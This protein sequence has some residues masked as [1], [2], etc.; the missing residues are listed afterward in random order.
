MRI[1]LAS[2]F[3]LG[4]MCGWIGL[5]TGAAV[6]Q[7][8]VP[9]IERPAD[10]EPV[11]P[12]AVGEELFRAGKFEEARTELRRC[13]DAGGESVDTLLPLTVMAVQTGRR[14]EAI[15]YS[16]RAVTMAPEDAE[17][18]YWHGRALMVAGR[19]EEARLEWEAGMRVSTEHKGILE[20]LAKLAMADGETA[21][22]YNIL[23]QL[24][25]SG[26]DDAWVHSLLADIAASKGLWKQ[27]LIHMDDVAVRETPDLEFLLLASEVSLMAENPESALNYGRSAVR[28]A[29]GP[30]SYAGL[31]EVF[32]AREEV[33]SALVYLRRAVELDPGASRARFNLA[34]ALEV[35]GQVEEAGSHFQAFLAA[36]PNDPVGQFNYGIHLQKLG[37]LEEALSHISR[38][39]DLEPGMLSARVVRVQM[40]EILGRYDEAL[41]D[42]AFLSESDPDNRS[43]LSDWERNIRLKR[44]GSA[45]S[46]AEGQVHLQHLVMSDA[47]AAELVASELEAG[48][49]F[50][51]LV[52]RFSVGP[53]SA[54]GGDIGWINPQDM[55]EPLRAAIANLGVNEISPPV[56]SGGLIH[57]FKRI[58]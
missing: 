44:E 11:D 7:Q 39:I 22:A 45:A 12:C 56:E 4:L 40:Y 2:F 36:E 24:Q 37:R 18:R 14:E 9:D 23:A 50:S 25:R 33:D 15:G 26:V 6:A 34:N 31:G 48:T 42:I 51:S 58:P 10:P 52:V 5:Q 43:E 17:A 49:D 20:G 53:G 1:F 35:L 13:L 41:A 29:P 21:K 38:S 16:G 3:I 32:F 54:R 8:V 57:I 30:A 47:T 27:T 28:L 46:H 55:V 19:I